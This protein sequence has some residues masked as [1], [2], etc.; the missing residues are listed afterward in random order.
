MGDRVVMVLLITGGMLLE[1]PDRAQATRPSTTAR[2]L[3]HSAAL[4]CS[5]GDPSDQVLAPRMVRAVLMR[6]T[7]HLVTARNAP[8]RDPSSC[9]SWAWT[10]CPASVTTGEK[11]EQERLAL[12]G[13][14][15]ATIVR[16]TQFHEFPG[17]ILQMTR[18]GPIAVVPRMRVQTVAA[19]AVPPSSPRSPP[20][21]CEAGGLQRLPGRS[22]LTFLPSPDA[23]CVSAASAPGCSPSG[24][25]EGPAWHRPAERS[26]RATLPAWSA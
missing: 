15:T 16:A 18:R 17:Q 22:G 21:R 2:P 14:L 5:P 7:I 23:S 4:R 24:S 19:S 8:T 25:P 6:G 13:S 26:C 1:I 10:E 3:G 12:G 20:D 11:L 9:R